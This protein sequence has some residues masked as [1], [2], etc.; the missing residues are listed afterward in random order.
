MGSQYAGAAGFQVSSSQPVAIG[1][2]FDNRSTR[3]DCFW[4]SNG[5]FLMNGA[6]P[7]T[8]EVASR[9][10][11]P[12]ANIDRVHFA[13]GSLVALVLGWLLLLRREYP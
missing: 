6:S 12:F 3:P 8:F 11:G 5:K 13:I 7:Q 4:C 1:G 10:D 9:D 2:D